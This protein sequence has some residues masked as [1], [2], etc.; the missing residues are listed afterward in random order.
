[1]EPSKLEQYRREAFP[2]GRLPSMEELLEALDDPE[3][4]DSRL[5]E[6]LRR[7]PKYASYL[8]RRRDIRT[9]EFS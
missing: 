5:L 8:R 6:Y 2:R 4:A 1:M 7:N 9:V 3:M